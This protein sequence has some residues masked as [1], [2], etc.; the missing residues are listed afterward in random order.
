ML[1]IV[2]KETKLPVL[3]CER[4]LETKKYIIDEYFF[5]N[6]QNHSKHKGRNYNYFFYKFLSS[7]VR[8]QPLL[9]MGPLLLKCISTISL[10][11]LSCFFFW[12]MTLLILSVPHKL[13]CTYITI[14]YIMSVSPCLCPYIWHRHFTIS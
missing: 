6:H 10:T 3:Q 1:V 14:S 4:F 12:R 7:L 9:F 13:F 8:S 2:T 11:L 5:I